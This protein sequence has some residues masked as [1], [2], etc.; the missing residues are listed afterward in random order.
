MEGDIRS[1]EFLRQWNGISR[2]EGGAS[3]VSTGGGESS[4]NYQNEQVSEYPGHDLLPELP[5]GGKE[6]HCEIRNTVPPFIAVYC[7]EVKKRRITTAP[8]ISSAPDFFTSG[9]PS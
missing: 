9:S 2:R 1:L 4:S 6:H 5:A 8:L 3:A 7:W